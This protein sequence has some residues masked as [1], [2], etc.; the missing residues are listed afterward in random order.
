MERWPSQCNR[1]HAT[2]IMRA[3]TFCGCW[4]AIQAIAYVA[5]FM[6]TGSIDT[7]AEFTKWNWI[8]RIVLFALYA[9]YWS[10]LARSGRRFAVTEIPATV[11]FLLIVI[12][13]VIIAATCVYLFWSRSW[14]VKTA[15]G[16]YHPIAVIV[17]NFVI[18]FIPPLV[19][20]LFLYEYIDQIA[21][22]FRSTMQ[23]MLL[24]VIIL[25]PSASAVVFV[26]IYCC[27][28]SPEDVY[29]V[30]FDVE[31][32]ILVAFVCILLFT[33]SIVSTVHRY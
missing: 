22:N 19:D 8:L 27:V 33:Y 18:H 23:T 13:D 12:L 21:L 1:V 5:Y 6:A 32:C 9:V 24:P 17:A 2:V 15:F 7:F 14:I 31:H 26:L 3:A 25:L 4:A 29:G 11:G 28:L 30:N 16:M 10:R 20:F